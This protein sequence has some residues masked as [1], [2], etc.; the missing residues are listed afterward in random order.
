MVRYSTVDPRA[1]VWWIALCV[2]PDHIDGVVD[3]EAGSVCVCVIPCDTEPY[4]EASC[5]AGSAD[6]VIE[7]PGC[8]LVAF[9]GPVLIGPIRTTY[10][11]GECV[12]VCAVLCRGTLHVSLITGMM[13]TEDAVAVLGDG[14]SR[15]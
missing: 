15:P 8:W 6:S 7:A 5:D 13:L 10:Y 11:E 1:V 3:V 14:R 9:P 12:A 4:F 2:A